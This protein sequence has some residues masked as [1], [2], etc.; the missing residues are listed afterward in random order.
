MRSRNA[1]VDGGGFPH[2]ALVMRCPGVVLQIVHFLL[3]DYVAAVIFRQTPLRA[4]ESYTVDQSGCNDE[5]TPPAIDLRHVFH[6]P[7]EY[8]LGRQESQRNG[9]SSCQFS[10]KIRFRHRLVGRA[11]RD[12]CCEEVHRRRIGHAILCACVQLKN[13]VALPPERIVY[14]NCPCRAAFSR[15][16]T[17]ELDVLRNAIDDDVIFLRLHPSGSRPSSQTSSQC[18]IAFPFRIADN[19]TF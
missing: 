9:N 19:F 18:G 11:L 6:P 15:S 5:K 1:G 8:G 13:F 4:A 14:H 16:G 3:A 12:V 7:P 10:G 2:I 17:V